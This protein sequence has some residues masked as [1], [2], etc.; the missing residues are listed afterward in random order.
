MSATNLSVEIAFYGGKLWTTDQLTNWLSLFFN[1][2]QSFS[3]H[4][5]VFGKP[6]IPS[7]YSFFVFSSRD[8]SFDLFVFYWLQTFKIRHNPIN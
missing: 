7:V 8:H 2:T 1:S 4:H 3:C 5:L 6:P